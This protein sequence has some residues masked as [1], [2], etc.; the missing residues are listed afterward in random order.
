MPSCYRREVSS[1]FLAVVCSSGFRLVNPSSAMAYRSVYSRLP[2]HAV[3][4][5][6][7]AAV[8]SVRGTR[9]LKGDPDSGAGATGEKLR[10]HQSFKALTMP[11]GWQREG[12]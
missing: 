4:D 8:G 2:G 3:F 12:T 10:P 11:L 9:R 6:G 5:D 7:G 1:K